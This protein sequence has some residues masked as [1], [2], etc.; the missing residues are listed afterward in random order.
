M[1][2]IVVRFLALKQNLI[3]YL[4]IKAKMIQIHCKE[5]YLQTHYTKKK[6]VNLARPLALFGFQFRISFSTMHVKENS[7]FSIISRKKIQKK[8]KTKRKNQKCVLC[9]PYLLNEYNFPTRIICYQ[10]IITNINCIIW[11]QCFSSVYLSS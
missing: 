3:K 9:R 5:N 1:S 4:L 2:V 7:T 11:V 8:L 10:I 6:T